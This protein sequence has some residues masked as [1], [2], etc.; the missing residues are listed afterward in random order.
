[1]DAFEVVSKSY[2]SLVDKLPEHNFISVKT[3]FSYLSFAPPN[4]N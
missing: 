3:R 4:V 1:M 2:F